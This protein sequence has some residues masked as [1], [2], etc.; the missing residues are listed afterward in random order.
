MTNF[1]KYAVI[2]AGGSGSRMGNS[3]VPKQFLK[4]KN[5]PI[6]NRTILRFREAVEDIQ[7]IVVLPKEQIS[8]YE[9]LCTQMHFKCDDL[10]FVVGGASRFH[11]VKNGIALIQEEALVAVHDAVRPLISNKLINSVFEE[12]AKYGSAV[13]TIPVN[14]SLREINGNNS[15][16]VERDRFRMVQTP[17]CFHA[18]KL[19]QAF[20]QE[21]QAHFTDEA[22]LME[23][24]GESIHLIE[25]EASN[26]KITFPEDLKIAEA[27]MPEGAV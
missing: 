12:A 19:K 20:E 21:Y 16:A 1:N 2:V 7:I 11:S 23:A 22:T 17:Q 25:G 6:I 13:P 8:Y 26:I 4:L 24:F 3:T 14:S 5:R 15:K 10:K 9:A 27:L 18:K